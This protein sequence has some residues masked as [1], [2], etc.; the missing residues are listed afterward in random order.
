G[1]HVR[2][3]GNARKS[4]VFMDLEEDGDEVCESGRRLCRQFSSTPG[5]A[6]FGL[7]NA[8]CLP[9]ERSPVR[10]ES[11]GSRFKGCSFD[12]ECEGRRRPCNTCYSSTQRNRI[13]RGI[14]RRKPE[15]SFRNTWSSPGE[16]ERAA[17]TWA[18]TLSSRW[19]RPRRCGSKTE[20][21]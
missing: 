19:R 7:R 14:P 6:N 2:K 1:S 4:A 15:R 11:P 8:S 12:R 9:A 16:S 18:A 13:G 10:K 3:G 5:R 21:R 20:R 17:T